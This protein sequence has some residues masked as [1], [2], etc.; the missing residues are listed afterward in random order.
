M[1]YRKKPIVVDAWQW[2]G[3]NPAKWPPYL[4]DVPVSQIV[5]GHKVIQLR[6]ATLE[7]DLCASRGDWIIRGVEGEVY[8]CKPNIFEATYE[9]ANDT[10]PGGGER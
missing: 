6:I 10:A 4:R 8:P 3:E 7:G 9:L 1:R 2:N 5:D